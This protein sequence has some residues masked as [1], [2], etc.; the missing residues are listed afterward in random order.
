MGCCASNTDK[1]LPPTLPV[2][3]ELRD[4]GDSKLM[5]VVTAP[6]D[7]PAATT[8]LAKRDSREARGHHLL[9]RAYRRIA[10]CTPRSPHVVACVALSADHVVMPRFETSLCDACVAGQL[11]VGDVLSICADMVRGVVF[12]AAC[13]LVHCDLASP[14]V[15]LE[16]VPGA[17]YGRCAWR[18][19]IIDLESL[20]RVCPRRGA[21]WRQHFPTRPMLNAVAR[22]RR[23]DDVESRVDVVDE[24]EAVGWTLLWA[25]CTVTGTPFPLDEY[26]V[27]DLYDHETFEEIRAAATAVGR[28]WGLHPVETRLLHVKTSLR[29]LLAGHEPPLP[30]RVDDGSAATSGNE[31]EDGMPAGT[32]A[33]MLSPAFAPVRAYFA[34]LMSL[35]RRAPP[36]DT[37]T[38]SKVEVWSDLVTLPPAE[39][40]MLVRCLVGQAASTRQPPTKRTDDGSAAE[41]LLQSD[42]D[43]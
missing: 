39:V 36:L 40:D 2:G 20:A 33:A 9:R 18:G 25:V 29:A 27:P 3:Y 13:G 30:Q 12:L 6:P 37:T 23:F 10:D 42:I 34:A 14:N 4:C 8:L 15:V 32:R 1:P 43:R 28:S 19:V 16:R 22:H 26:R 5:D 38:K 31:D 35:P 24:L 41:Q 7:A 11:S 17:G 21:L